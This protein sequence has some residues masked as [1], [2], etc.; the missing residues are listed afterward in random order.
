MRDPSPGSSRISAKAT[1]VDQQNALQAAIWREEY[2][3]DFQLDGADNSNQGNDATLITDY[4][5]D[6]AALGTKTA[7]VGSVVWLSPPEGLIGNVDQGLVALPAI[8]YLTKTT[9]VSSVTPA[10]YGRTVAF[11]ATVTNSSS[12]GGTTPT[13]SIQFQING[14]NFGKPVPLGTKGTAGI[15]ESSL[16]VG[17]YTIDAIFI[18]TGTFATSPTASCKQTITRDSTAVVVS[19]SARSTTKNKAVTFSVT[20]A[21]ESPGSTAI[22]LGTVVFQIDGASKGTVRLSGGK[23]VL[24][25]IKLSVGTHTVTVY[26]TPANADYAA[27]AGELI[28]GEMVK[29]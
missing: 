15:T 16:N 17:T 11:G 20:V 19:S 14:A 26:Y 1:T 2:G 18:P 27:N 4:K 10:A 5:A 21:N 25:G 24:K 9:V 23:A 7:A 29:K 12:P 13:G 6:L 3:T 8:T 28:G 22:P